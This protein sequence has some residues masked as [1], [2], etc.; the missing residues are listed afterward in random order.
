MKWLVYIGPLFLFA[1]STLP[2][3]IQDPPGNDLQLKQ[4]SE[5]FTSYK[6][7]FIRWGGKIITVN[8]DEHRSVLQIVQF[9]LNNSGRPDV[10]DKSQGR[11]L[12]ESELFLDP[13][14]FEVGRLAT[15]SGVITAQQK[16]QIDKKQLL[17]PVIQMKESHLWP[18]KKE[19]RSDFYN[20][21]F[22]HPYRVNG[23]YGWSYYGAGFRCF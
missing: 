5:Q 16:R 21:G 13:E 23:F 6:N 3:T 8:N 12:I 18:K 14:V 4:V 17:L 7:N 9:P 2:Q 1:C 19:L 10:D 22:S 11:F 20:N 15:F